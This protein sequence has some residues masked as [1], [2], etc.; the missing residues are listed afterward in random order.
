MK[1]SPTGLVALPF[2]S[3]IMIANT[4][5]AAEVIISDDL[6]APV[7]TAT[8][9]TGIAGDILIDATGS[10]TVTTG[11]AVTLN[12]DNTVTNEGSLIVEDGDASVGVLIMG[13]YLGQFQN[14]GSL[15]LQATDGETRGQDKTGLHLSGI[16]SFTGD[17]ANGETGNIS[18]TGDNSI[19][20]H[21]DAPLIGDFTNEGTVS[22]QGSDNIGIL[23]SNTIDGAFRNAG[24][25]ASSVIIVDTDNNPDT[26]EIFYTGPAVAIG[27]SIS[28]GFIN[29]GLTYEELNDDIADDPTLTG[30]ISSTGSS[31]AVLISPTL[32][33]DSPADL[34]LG[35][36]SAIA[37]GESF[38]NLGAIG[39]NSQT[40]SDVGAVRIEGQTVGLDTYTTTLT[41]GFRNDGS[42]EA[43]A[44]GADA[45]A[46]S[47]GSLVVVPSILNN[48]TIV[49]QGNGETDASNVIA[50]D[51]AASP[52]ST[53]LTNVG[54]ISAQRF[55]DLGSATAIRDTTGTLSALTNTGTISA[56]HST[57]ANGQVTATEKA[58]ALD[59]SLSTTGMTLINQWAVDDL[60]GI[61]GIINGDIFLGSGNDD[62]YLNSGAMT[63][64]LS[65][66][67]GDDYLY[68]G[69]DGLLTGDLINLGGTLS[70]NIDGTLI[71][72][73]P[74]L[75]TFSDLTLGATSSIWIPIDG[76]TGTS[77]AFTVTN[78]ATISS[79][80]TFVPYFKTLLT[81]PQTFDIVTAGTL[82]L[83]GGLPSLNVEHV[84]VIYDIEILLDGALQLIVARKTVEALGLAPYQ[85]QIY[86]PLFEVVG[87]TPTFTAALHS[88]ATGEEL[89]AA[90]NRIAPDDTGASLRLAL[91]SFDGI[92]SAALNSQQHSWAAS[93]QR[94][95]F[96]ITEGGFY[97]D[98][99]ETDTG[100]GYT[101]KQFEMSAG[102]ETK[103]Q[104]FDRLG[105]AVSLSALGYRPDGSVPS[106]Y[107]AL[108]TWFS[109]Y[110]AKQIGTFEINAIGSYASTDNTSDRK[111][112]FGQAKFIAEADWTSRQWAARIESKV[113]FGDDAFYLEPRASVSYLSLEEDNYV[114]T[115]DVGITVQ[116]SDVSMNGFSA[117]LATVFGIRRESRTSILTSQ[118]EL[119][120]RQEFGA[121]PYDR[122]YQFVEGTMPFTYS[123]MEDDEGAALVGLSIFS[124]SGQAVFGV[125]YKGT[126]AT[127][128]TDHQLQAILRW[129]F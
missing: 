50:I 51:I 98:Q 84:P 85:S 97:R 4:A 112:E 100:R 32:N 19:G 57:V 126:F 35:P 38:V 26:V 105:V 56:W 2:L 46:I 16:A 107:S 49:A 90:L 93:R 124:Q 5:L 37:S 81:D 9:D 39:A 92:A 59:F 54:T 96:W 69:Q 15:T 76:L 82:T 119:G 30:S 62:V 115:G 120:W 128:S 95:H 110:G 12:S 101:A 17:I 20:V 44:V 94:A 65:F 86:D 14:D 11:P 88:V 99:A 42:I 27:A 109:V 8:I 6:T 87:L 60:D 67:A 68:I 114:E 74:A 66:G 71:L 28:G 33:G 40:G 13:G 70:S 10:I 21:L 116:A 89:S 117:E 102:A 47:I 52:G 113:R 122:T 91:L 79:D 31:Y 123:S 1:L 77:A 29:D 55:G 41:G 23:V 80:A 53:T 104:A 36:V 118:L 125:E 111:V 18:L 127:D 34:T 78:T 7:D 129:W 43:S 64:D 58:T 25:I 63:G 22:V 83:D 75:T 48:G 3:L 61:T 108:S 103:T 106:P 72:Q 45:T 24:S 73:S 121:T